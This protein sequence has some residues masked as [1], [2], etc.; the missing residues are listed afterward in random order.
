MTL[1]GLDMNLLQA[2]VAAAEHRSFTQAAAALNRTQGA[3]SMQIGRLEDRLGVLLFHRQHGGV[4]LTSAGEKLLGYARRI[5]LLEEEAVASLQAHEAE[6]SVRLGVMDDYGS[7]VLPP[8]LAR[9]SAAHS[10]IHIAVETGLTATMPSRLGQDFDLVV[11]MHAEGDG[12]GR[13]LRREQAL[14]AASPTHAAEALDPLP[15]ALYPAGCLFRQWAIEALNASGRRWSIAFES[16]SLS[17]VES[18]AAEGLAV[19]VVKAGTFPPRLRRLG[20]LDGMPPLPR[21]DICLHRA[22]KLSR[23]AA[24]LADHV[25]AALTSPP[26]LRGV[27]S[28]GPTMRRRDSAAD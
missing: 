7:V 8:L 17:A 24:L 14:W 9:F 3:L 12:G 6:G 20:E 1:P 10:R 4:V 13:L 18:I 25:E 19:T 2:L 5:L 16:Q 27:A 23:A 28:K 15:V 22:A 11:A 26:A 21:A